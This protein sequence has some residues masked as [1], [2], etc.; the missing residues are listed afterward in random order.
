LTD[1]QSQCYFDFDFDLDADAQLKQLLQV[2]GNIEDVA[3]YIPASAGESAEWAAIAKATE[4]NGANYCK[5]LHGKPLFTA[6]YGT[7]TVNLD[8][9]KDLLNASTLANQTNSPKATK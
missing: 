9:L 5:P 2:L 6:L 1:R 8:E 4:E 3:R 7:Y